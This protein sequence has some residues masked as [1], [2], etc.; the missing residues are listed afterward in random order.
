MHNYVIHFEFHA[1]FID[2]VDNIIG[3]SFLFFLACLWLTRPTRGMRNCNPRE[4]RPSKS[5][6]DHIQLRPPTLNMPNFFCLFS[7]TMSLKP[8]PPYKMKCFKSNITSKS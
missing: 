4:F 7:T 8:S 6:G 2:D 3:Y 5:L 1:I